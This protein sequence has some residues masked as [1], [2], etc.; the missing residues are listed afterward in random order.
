MLIHENLLQ[1]NNVILYIKLTIDV[2]TIRLFLVY[3]QIIPSIPTDIYL[4][5]VY[6]VLTLI[7]L[8]SKLSEDIYL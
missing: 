7:Q 4:Q 1:R 6:C 8:H 2:N 3:L 5:T